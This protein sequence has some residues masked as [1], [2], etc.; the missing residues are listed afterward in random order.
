MR[1]RTVIVWL[2]LG[3]LA[4]PALAD[5]C[6][7]T[8]ASADRSVSDS[9]PALLAAVRESGACLTQDAGLRK[10]YE[11]WLGGS[12]AFHVIQWTHSMDIAPD[13]ALPSWEGYAGHP[14]IV[15]VPADRA[16]RIIGDRDP[17]TIGG[18][19]GPVI[20]DGV[21]FSA[22]DGTAVVIQADRN[23]LLR[24]R[25]TESGAAAN[26][27]P[28]MA[29]AAVVVRGRRTHIV[30]AEIAHNRGPGVIAREDPHAPCPIEPALAQGDRL[31]LLASRIAENG[32]PGLL[33]D[34]YHAAV[35]DS[36]IEENRGEGILTRTESAA[37]A[38]AKG[39]PVPETAWHTTRVERTGFRANG[40]TETSG[41]AVTRYPL[42][43]PIRLAVVSPP[44]G[45]EIVIVGTI[46]REPDANAPWADGRLD[47]G[48]L[49][50]ECF[51]AAPE[52]IQG[53]QY[54]GRVESIDPATRRFV[55]HVPR[56]AL[57]ALDTDAR[58]TATVVDTEHGNTSP[59]AAP[60]PLFGGSDGDGDGVPNA[61]E[62]RNHDGHVD[63]DETDPLIADTDGDGLTDGEE[64]MRTGR[65]AG[66]ILADP[67]RLDP[68]S[69]D[70]DGD[71]LPDGVEAGVAIPAPVA[72]A[73]DGSGARFVLAGHCEEMLR[74]HGVL[75]LANGVAWDPSAPATIENL[76]AIYDQDPTTTTDPT[77]PDTDRDGVRD[78][79]EDWNLNGK[80]DSVAAPAHENESKNARVRGSGFAS[81]SSARFGGAGATPPAEGARAPETEDWNLN[82]K[83]DSVA[84]SA[85]AAPPP[86]PATAAKAIAAMLRAALSPQWIETDPREPDSDGDGLLD[87]EEGDRNAD[88]AMAPQ[89]TD[90]LQRDTDDDGIDDYTEVQRLRSLPG[91][92][93]SDGDGLGDGIEAGAIHPQ[94]ARKECVGLQTAGSNFASPGALGILQAD[95]DNDRL[96]DGLEDANRN[97]WL[98]ALETDPTVADSDGD[99]QSDYVETTGDLD[100]DGI[101]DIARE[102][103]SN[104]PTCAPPPTFDDAD[105][106]GVPNA[107]DDDS[108]NDGCGDRD[109]GATA[110]FQGKVKRCG[111]GAS[112]GAG[113]GPSAAPPSPPP[114][115]PAAEAADYFA[116]QQFS[117]G[118]G[119]SL[120]PA[121]GPSHRIAP[122]PRSP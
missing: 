111:A 38:C 70:S 115:S 16:V 41:I 110:A 114:S 26:A 68:R 78:G 7:V 103:L 45:G 43:A 102:Y 32:G 23:T 109:E 83:R 52:G 119:C 89:E 42:P 121:D 87:G 56:A 108:D 105:C 28:F 72:G 81:P 12:E 88:G 62:D 85:P 5:P 113:P 34:S 64:I 93:D 117:G 40:G 98:D 92:C 96:P 21:I 19:G 97:G 112:G 17:I 27:D 51:L 30:D 54:V 76:A 39:G 22:F 82:G 106:D 33:V 60:V 84:V 86:A 35:I 48:A 122:R 15:R 61:T 4:R 44:E 13:G 65:L 104:G 58:L 24:T 73:R 46:A 120:R 37:A 18:S 63:Q 118:G 3:G 77:A 6:T 67:L 100:G 71:C 91:D 1:L 59:F 47:L 69:P 50:V 101:S 36:A 90:P 9:L 66:M 57:P 11:K 29:H 2:I 79:E 94:A 14:L 49:R 116:A 74:R 53:A 99:G 107:R 25:I 75:T 95:S 80:R 20:V 31:T 55:V 10:G 8:S